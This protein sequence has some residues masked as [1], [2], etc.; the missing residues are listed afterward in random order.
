M[1]SGGHLPGPW[2]RQ[3]KPAKRVLFATTDVLNHGGIQRFNRTLIAALRVLGAELVVLSLNDPRGAQVGPDEVH[4]AIIVGFGRDK[5]QFASALVRQLASSQF[6]TLLVGHL[7]FVRM[8]ATTCRL[9]GVRVPPRRML[10][11]HGLEI[12]HSIRGPVRRALR[13]MTHILSVSSFTRDSILVQAPELAPLRMP[14]FPNALAH[15]WVARAERT[16]FAPAASSNG[17]GHRPFILS[18]T[19]LGTNERTKGI[20]TVLEALASAD[21]PAL[22]YV[23]AGQG[24]GVDFLRGCAGRLGLAG[25]VDFK[26]ALPDPELAELYRSC[27]AFVLPS[28]QEGFGIVYLEAMFFGAPVIAARAKGVVDV[29]DDGSTGL[30][31]EFGDVVGLARALER[32]ASDAA[33]RREL[34]AAGRRQV[35]GDGPFAFSAFVARTARLCGIEAPPNS[36]GCEWPRFSEMGPAAV[37]V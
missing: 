5:L 29:V 19:R 23:V 21:V 14:V 24:D 17:R 15:S 7:H 2:Q 13:G 25:R 18:V 9:P 8:V 6:D 10:I 31:V 12:W 36:A 20:V 37:R 33:L 30:L 28:G 35:T 34:S 11:A 3:A 4:G 16:S 26:G 27:V 22:D 1:N 32:V